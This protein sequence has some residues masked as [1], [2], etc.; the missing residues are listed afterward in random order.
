MCDFKNTTN[1]CMCKTE[2]DSQIQ[3]TTCGSQRGDG[4]GERE[5]QVMG[6]TDTNY[7]V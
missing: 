1:E 2:T 3:E 6:L 5:I 7:Y 4:R